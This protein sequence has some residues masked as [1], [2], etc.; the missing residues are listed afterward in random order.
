MADEYIL[1]KLIAE[2]RVKNEVL[3]AK[4]VLNVILNIHKSTGLNSL[5][6]SKS[7]IEL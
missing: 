3:V 5:G 1:H 2:S 7:A 4:Q 6:C